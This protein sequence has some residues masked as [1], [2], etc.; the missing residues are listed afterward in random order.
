MAEIRIH[1][2]ELR[3]PAIPTVRIH[4]AELRVPAGI[5]VRIHH[6]ELAFPA[7]PTA[8][9]RLHYAAMTVPAGDGT[10]TPSGIR[11]FR[12]DGAWWDVE[13]RQRGNGEWL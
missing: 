11:Q 4:H 3:V 9:V 5:T 10:V 1:H 8:E 12:S 6:A 2:A 13:L 7:L